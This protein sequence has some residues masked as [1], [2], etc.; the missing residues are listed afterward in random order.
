MASDAIQKLRGSVSD[1]RLVLLVLLAVLSGS[2]AFLTGY[3]SNELHLAAL[4]EKLDA[5][6]GHLLIETHA[7]IEA[8]STLSARLRDAQLRLKAATEDEPLKKNYSWTAKA[9]ASNQQPKTGRFA[10]LSA[11]DESKYDVM[12]GLSSDTKAKYAAWHGY[13]Y[14]MHP[15]RPSQISSAGLVVDTLY[16]HWDAFEW[17]IWT[18]ID[19]LITNAQLP[20]ESIVAMVDDNKHVVLSRDWGETQI[21]P[22][23]MMVRTTAEGL[24]FMKRLASE[25][26]NN[27]SRRSVLLA[28][29]D[30]MQAARAAEMEFV[31][32]VPQHLINAYP[33][34]VFKHE[35]YNESTPEHNPSH[36]FWSAGDLFVHVVNCVAQAPD[37]IDVSCCNGIAAFYHRQFKL[38][39]R[40]ALRAAAAANP[41]VP[42]IASS[43]DWRVAF[44]VELGLRTS[45]PV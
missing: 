42:A 23:V 32:F 8:G 28:L 31:Q 9:S 18:D 12:E 15:V 22:A 38:S 30:G 43:D 3:F 40:Q 44:G 20:L 36:A 34:V 11:Y 45:A 25:V 19:V 37:N 41:D 16:K 24:A 5:G 7:G 33:K 2:V 29:R 39:L 1:G 4:S 6:L 21:S 10:L 35:P 13:S 26:A 27:G 17:V 14:F